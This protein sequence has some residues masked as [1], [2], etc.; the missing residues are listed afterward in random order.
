MANDNSRKLVTIAENMHKL[1]DAGKQAEHDAFWDAYQNKGNYEDTSFT[2]ERMFSFARWTDANFYPKYDV[3][4]YAGN[5]YNAYYFLANTRISNL[6]QRLRDCGVVLDL[7]KGQNCNEAFAWSSELTHIPTVSL[8]SA[9]LIRYIFAGCP[10]LVE[11]EKLILPTDRLFDAIDN[12]FNND[13]ALQSITIEG[14][15]MQNGFDWKWS[16]KLNK[17]SITSIVNALSTTTSGLTVTLSKT[18]VGNA[19]ATSAGAADGSTS[20]EW[21]A[22][23]NTRTNWTIALA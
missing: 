19:F 6:S 22:L 2:S 11:I 14:T 17:P 12:C 20:A 23:K 3:K 18:A 4:A 9:T 21:T 8:V 13:V 10:K 15:I 1:Y 7:S 16:T 5:N